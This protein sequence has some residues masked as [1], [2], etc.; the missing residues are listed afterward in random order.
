MKMKSR[1]F[2]RSIVIAGH[3]TSVSLEDE[4]WEGLKE[5]A[6]VRH[7]SLSELI[8]AINLDRPGGII[9]HSPDRTGFLCNQLSEQKRDDLVERSVNRAVG[10]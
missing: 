10:T 9:H 3:K 8:T 5:I 6:A 4:F 1:I 2:K 7:L